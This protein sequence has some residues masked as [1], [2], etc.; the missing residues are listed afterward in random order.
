ATA[1]STASCERCVRLIDPRIR[2]THAHLSRLSNGSQCATC[3]ASHQ[4]KEHVMQTRQ[5]GTELKVHPVGLG[6]MGMSFAYG[7]QDEKDA[8]ATLRHAVEIGV[9]FFDT[10]E[11]YGPFENEI[12][13]GKALKPFRDRVTIATK[14]GFKISDGGVGPQR[15]VGVDSR[16]EHVREVAD[17]SLK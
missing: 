16:P 8:I 12:L 6:C 4:N 1:A 10:A 5:L 13:V 9:N 7:G 2:T 3:T 14:F 15:M 17:A 11:L